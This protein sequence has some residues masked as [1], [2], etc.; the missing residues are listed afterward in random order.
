MQNFLH[1]E[2]PGIKIADPIRDS[3]AAL[4]NDPI[5]SAQEGINITK[6]LIDTAAELI[7]RNLFNYTIFAI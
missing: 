5:K 1:H 7:Q 6:S 4:N 2:V 3:L